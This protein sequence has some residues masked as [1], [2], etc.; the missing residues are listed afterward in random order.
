MWLLK[1]E[2]GEEAG[3][4]R[5]PPLVAAAR[6]PHDS[7]GKP[8]VSAVSSRP[9]AAPWECGSSVTPQSS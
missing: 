5:T 2:K 3:T 9:W 7:P 6:G 8:S 4:E 1:K